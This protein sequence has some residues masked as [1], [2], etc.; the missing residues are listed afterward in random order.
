MPLLAVNELKTVV[1]EEIV[2]KATMLCDHQLLMRKL[3]D[4]ISADTKTAKM[5]ESI[6][7]QL[8]NRGPMTEREL[9]QYTNATR[10]GLFIFNQSLS[11]LTK[12]GEVRFD[13]ENNTYAIIP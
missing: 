2:I 1:D 10:S 7:R 5:E 3:Y 13:E 12:A 9:K 8:T 6:R 11:N 4:P